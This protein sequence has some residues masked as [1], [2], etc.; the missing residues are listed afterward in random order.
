MKRIEGFSELVR[1]RSWIN[2][3]TKSITWSTIGALLAI[4]NL[5]PSI[6]A[7]E[8]R[9]CHR[10]WPSKGRWSFEPPYWETLGCP[11]QPFSVEN[12]TQCLKGRTVYFIGN[13]V[14]RQGAFGIVDILGGGLVKRENQRDSCPKHETTWG[15]SCHQEYSGV[16]IKYLFVQYMDGFNYS[17][18]NGFPFYRWKDKGV[19][20]T[21][22]LPTGLNITNNGITFTV[23]GKGD[24]PDEYKQEDPFWVDDNCIH[25][26]MR[27]CLAAFFSGSTENDVLVFT[28]GMSY[29]L[30]SPAEEEAMKFTNVSIDMRAWLLASAANFKA[31]L[32]ATFKGQIFRT[33]LAQL[34]P[35]GRV[36]HMTPLMHNTNQAV[37]PVWRPSN[38][39]NAT[40]TWYTIDQWAINEG[41]ETTFYNDHVHFNGALTS[42][43]LHQV[44]NE[45]C[46]NGGEQRLI[47]WPRVDLRGKVITDGFSLVYYVDPLGMKRIV[48]ANASSLP[49]YLASLH[50]LHMSADEL[51]R[52]S[53]SA[54]IPVLNNGSLVRGDGER[55]VHLI[56]GKEISEIYSSAVFFAHGWDFGSVIVVPKFVLEWFE[57]GPVVDKRY[58]R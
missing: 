1:C 2:T 36:K 47:A 45:L 35:T 21:G 15:D 19:W 20:T 39:S 3:T 49:P 40:R 29:A 17:D 27:D 57:K 58:I 12:V 34:H 38:S 23:T 41:R 11:N 30:H 50:H 22:H 53:S 16:K 6:I 9:W 26:S 25:H 4:L 48:S 42:A 13:S 5:L 14:A 24:S 52:I 31:N 51:T 56:R 10:D 18:R 54:S 8:A 44:L 46:P 28:L 37:W 55:T 33:T 7:H 43:M 32:A